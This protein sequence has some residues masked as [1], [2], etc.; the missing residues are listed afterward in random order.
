MLITI[1]GTPLSS[2]QPLHDLARSTWGVLGFHG[3]RRLWRLD[4]LTPN[5]LARVSLRRSDDLGETYDALLPLV[6][7]PDADAFTTD[8]SLDV[9]DDHTALLAWQGALGRAT[10][11]GPCR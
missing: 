9:V 10:V 1:D 2:W 11:R 3:A 7:F 6:P 8:L 4:I 5:I